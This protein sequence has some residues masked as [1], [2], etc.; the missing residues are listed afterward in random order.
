MNRRKRMNRGKI[1]FLNGVSSSGKSTLAEEL[2]NTMPD[3][4]HMGLDD[5]D[6]FIDK[7]E[8]R[9]NG[10]LISVETEYFFHRTISMFSDKGVNLIVDH[11]LHD[12]FTRAD[13]FEVLKN[14]PVLFVGVHCPVEELE[15]REKIRGD[16]N[17]GQAKRQLEYVHKNEIYD[18]EVDTFTESVEEC[19]KKVIEAVNSAKCYDGW[20]RTSEN[21]K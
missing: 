7:M 18:V 9:E 10:H 3:Y 17:V 2:V 16:R 6:I 15:R 8:D 4:F 5:F 21:Y 1:I 19:S 11:I 14:Y 12:N 20:L 13:C